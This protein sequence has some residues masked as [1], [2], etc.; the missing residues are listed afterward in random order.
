M[1]TNLKKSI[2]IRQAES[3]YWRLAHAQQLYL[4][5]SQIIP[6][7]SYHVER[8]PYARDNAQNRLFRRRQLFLYSKKVKPK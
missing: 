5:L 8:L 4:R 2:M 3:L 1:T 6:F 7:F